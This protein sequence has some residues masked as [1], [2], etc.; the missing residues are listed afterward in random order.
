MMEKKNIYSR[1]AISFMLM[2]MAALLLTV[3]LSFAPVQGQQTEVS[4]GT[5]AAAVGTTASPTSGVDRLI[6]DTAGA[7]IVTMHQATGAARFIRFA[8]GYTLSLVNGVSAQAEAEAFFA[9]YGDAFGITDATSQL[10]LAES[11]TDGL[12][13]SHLTYQQVHQGVKVFAALLRLHFDAA[14]HITSVNGVFVPNL[15][16]STTPRIAA[17]TAGAAALAHVEAQFQ[18]STNAAAAQT[19]LLVYHA[20]LIQDISAPVYLVYEVEISNG[21]DIREFVYLDAHKGTVIN[22]VTGIHDAL[23]RRIYYQSYPSTPVWQEGD[24]L[25]YVNADPAIQAGVNDLI[26][27]AED[28]YDVFANAFGRD[29]WDGA[30]ALMHSV[31]DDP[32]I[33]C[34]NAN[35][36]GVT[37]NY[38]DGVTG[39]DT[40]AHEWTHAY[41]EQTHGL[42]YQWQPGALNESYSDIYGEVVDL[43]NGADDDTPGGLRTDNSCSVFSPPMPEMEVNAG[44]L[45]GNYAAGSASFGPALDNIGITGDMIVATDGTAAPTEACNAIT[46]DLTGQIAFVRRGT[47]G[48]A[49]KVK[50]AQNAGAIA[51]VV[52]NHVTGGD[53]V[54]AMGG[55]DPTITIPSIFIGYTLGNNIEAQLG[56]GST[57]NIT[58]RAAAGTDNSYRWLSG[59]SDPAFGTAI[60]D[61]WNPNCH[62]DP[63]LVTDP[64]YYVCGT[65]DGGGVH[66]NSGVPNHGFALLVDGGNFNGQTVTGIGL[67]KASHIYF[68]AMATYQTPTTDFTD[69]ADSLEASCVDLVTAGTD[70]NDF[71]GTPSGEIMTAADCTEL[72][73]MIAAVE[74]RTE[75]TFCNFQPMLDPNAPALCTGTGGPVTTI[76]EDTFETDPSANW[77]VSNAGVY[78]EWTPRD[79]EWVSSLPGGVAGSAFFAVDP[80]IGDC[81]AG[82]NDQSGVIYLE[83]PSF[84]VPANAILR[85]AFDHWVATESGYDGGNVKISV[86]GGAYELIAPEFFTF[87]SYN[88]VMNPAGTSPMAGED[89]FT[90]TDGG[91]VSGSWGESQLLLA[92]YAAP[93]DSVQ[94]RFDLGTDGCAG[95]VGWYVDNVQAYSC[96]ADPTD[97]TLTSFGNVSSV[98]LPMVA[99]SVGLLVVGLALLVARGRKQ[100]G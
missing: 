19:N 59:E 89:A 65:N 39:D 97:V 32:S 72:A 53:A 55:T 34:P 29:S 31:F 98:S 24:A 23:D 86:N 78:A 8:N 36:N 61:M 48:F 26:D 79:W 49:V 13:T 52:A 33:T 41:T 75:P 22:Q 62:A 87:N 99:A 37:T 67:L 57:V 30:G 28:T 95:I 35:W 25:P 68:R 14:N 81:T 76:F 84:V 3:A 5:V 73:D 83:S 94:L 17:Q 56:G 18:S 80:D 82:S 58:M 60:R 91:A 20:G 46:N 50:N 74:L 66:T 70:L 54:Q 42:I 77:T 1:R 40:V 12:G 44:P 88:E 69:H 16:V 9:L 63:G 6:A 51:V 7:A 2:A 96:E 10:V 64:S 38:C 27:F 45:A 21:H 43:I 93:G 71:D 85:L 11:G 90:G 92:N 47:C 4:G 100:E 15:S